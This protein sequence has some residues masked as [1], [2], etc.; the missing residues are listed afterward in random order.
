MNFQEKIANYVLGNLTRRHFPDIALTALN[1]GVESESLLIL[2]GMSVEDNSFELEQYFKASLKE[3]GIMLPKSLDAAKI[4][5]SF[6]LKEMIAYPE[7]GFEI[8]SKIDNQIYKQVDWSKVLGKVNKEFVGEELGLEHMYTWYR[9]LQDFE[10]NGMLLYYNN[11]PKQEQKEK[12]EL[13][14]IS[15]AKELLK[16]ISTHNNS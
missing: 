2:A 7:N 5:L 8:M 16:K 4:L 14:L 15:E 12:F 11:L 1:H 3:L 6:Y 10:D 13:H 9:E